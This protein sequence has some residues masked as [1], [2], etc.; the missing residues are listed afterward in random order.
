MATLTDSQIRHLCRVVESRNG[1]DVLT[2][3]T[4]LASLR[5]LHRLGLTEGRDVTD[6]RGNETRLIFATPAG[7][8]EL[9]RLATDAT[10]DDRAARRV[11]EA[12]VAVSK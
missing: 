12:L 2:H 6:R 1:Y 10:L 9:R 4:R 3:G 5:A 11:R 8:A 7:I